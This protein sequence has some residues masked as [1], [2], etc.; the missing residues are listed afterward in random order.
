MTW[1]MKTWYLKERKV[2]EWENFLEVPYL[3][4]GTG[5]LCPDLPDSLNSAW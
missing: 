2:M 4:Y 1:G 5:I 3:L